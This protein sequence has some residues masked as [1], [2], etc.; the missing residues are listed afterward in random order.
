MTPL[1]LTSG[2]PGLLIQPSIARGDSDFDGKLTQRRG[3]KLRGRG[4]GN[5]QLSRLADVG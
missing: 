1:H 3:K 5:F 4:L 2:A